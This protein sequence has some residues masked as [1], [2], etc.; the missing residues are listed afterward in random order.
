[1]S[2]NR[3]SVCVS[4]TTI[5]SIFSNN[6]KE[7]EENSDDN[8][9]EKII[10]IQSIYKGYYIRNKLKK[11]YRLPR[12]IQRKI[13]WYM[14]SDVYL[15]HY[16]STLTKLLHNKIVEFVLFN[17]DSL[18]YHKK[19]FQRNL[20]LNLSKEFFTEFKYIVRTIVKYEQIIDFIK[21]KKY[22]FQI[23]LFIL[24]Y[25]FEEYYPNLNTEQYINKN[26]KFIETFQKFIMLF[27]SYTE[28]CT[29]Y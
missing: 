2:F 19:S 4:P 27:I 12:D 14:N 23:H 7:K 13:I 29:F 5:I 26:D 22:L 25:Y 17:Y 11:F 3:K 15:R 24:F 8:K 28:N 18:N 20:Y 6:F 1:M 16:Y 9:E 10:K 21:I